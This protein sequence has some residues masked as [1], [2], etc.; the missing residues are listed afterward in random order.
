VKHGKV[1]GEK[2]RVKLIRAVSV[3]TLIVMVL[4]VGLAS[5]LE[6][7][8]S[9]VELFMAGDTKARGEDTSLRILFTNNADLNLSVY[10]IGVHFDWMDTDQ[11]IGT[12]YA[13]DP[14]IV[15]PSKNLRSEIINYTV[16]TSASLGAHSYYIG[17]D[18]Y[19]AN[20]DPFSWTSNEYT[21]Y[22]TNPTNTN[23]PTA[24]PTPSASNPETMDLTVLVYGLVVAAVVAVI[25]AV[26]IITRRGGKS[27][28]KSKSDEPAAPKSEEKP[29]D[30]QDFSI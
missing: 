2:N 28:P 3:V 10:Y 16:P 17:V 30:G 15:E 8:E 20:G 19:D 22:V 25:V 24:T 29:D 18:G 21:L 11:L 14:K 9:S 5:A 27:S 12:N 6:Q 26:V 23:A 1:K 4:S 7:N 13:S